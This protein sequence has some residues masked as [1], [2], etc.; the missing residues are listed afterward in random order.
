MIKKI[1]VANVRLGMH[2]H[3][4]CG[5]WMDHPFWKKSFM[6]DRQKDLD[7]LLNSSLEAVLID[8]DKGLDEVLTESDQGVDEDLI[9]TGQ[10]LDAE[11]P[12][13]TTF[14]DTPEPTLAKEEQLPISTSRQ[15]ELV[16]ARKIHAKTKQA[17]VSMFSEVRM[18][19]AIEVE[20]VVP[21]VDEINASMTR[22]SSA[23][24]SLIRL[25][26]VDEYTY[27]H[28]VAVCTLMIA[29]GKKLGMEEDEL[30][31]A[32][33][34]GLLHDVGKMAIPGK[35]LNKPGRLTDEEFMIVK[36]HP[37]EGWKMLKKVGTVS[38]QVLDVCLHHH[39]RVD[40]TGYPD[41]ISGDDLTLIARM[42]AVC[43]VY[44]AIS[45]DRC[46]K[47]GWQPA[48]SLTKMAEWKDGHFD[49]KVFHAFVK[50][51][52]IYPND[53]LVKLNSGRLAL[54]LEQSEGDLTSPIIK[55]FFSPQSGS[56]IKPEII[57]LSTTS[58]SIDNIE[59]PIKWN[60]DLEKI[61]N[62]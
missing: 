42:G 41:K 32:G 60:F 16:A 8:T 39:E 56:L 14:L 4:L 59:D 53:T 61:L 20:N 26:N 36:A 5:S 48:E 34:A 28:S 27:L 9:E 25:K 43:D 35:V 2:I 52:G 3:S 31:Q 11:E 38:D 44:D 54:V 22:N 1:K 45:S 30:K 55:V 33:I 50:T 57:D 7:T 24:L 49:E 13:S 21:L 10:D 58:D 15:E 62:M 6:L 46:Y 51:I 23:F 17:V 29:L 37:F 12:N 18:G 19:K 47:K 40:G